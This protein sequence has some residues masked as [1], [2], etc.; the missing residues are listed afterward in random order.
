MNDNMLII[1]DAAF[2]YVLKNEGGFVNDPVDAGGPTNMGVTQAT[3]SQWTG[4]P[5]SAEDVQYLT[6]EDAKQIYFWHFYKPLGCDIM[7]SQKAAAAIFDTG[8]LYGLHTAAMMTQQSINI[9]GSP[10]VID[11][12]IGPDTVSALNAIPDNVFIPALH[13]HVLVRID[14][15]ILA[16]PQ[17]EKFRKGW[18]TRALRLLTLV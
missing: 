4:R 14:D 11:A 5:S 15:V 12:H 16:H 2:S 13:A 6:L 8:V 9:C 18:T 10:L 7:K 17:N 1:Y 3:L